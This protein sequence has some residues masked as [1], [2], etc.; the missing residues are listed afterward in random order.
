MTRETRARWRIDRPRND[1]LLRAAAGERTP[2]PPVWLMRQAGRF[3]PQYLALRRECGLELE[4]LFVN[5]ELAAQITLLPMRLGVDAL[6]LF[7][8]ILTPLGP[9]GAPFV[10]RPGPM[11]EKPIRSAADIDRLREYDPAEALACVPDSIQC[12]LDAVDGEIP[13]LG[14]AGSPLT[15]ATF[16]IE[17]GSAAGDVSRTRELM[18]TDP[19][20]VHRLLEK[21]ADMT[22]AYLTMQIEAGVHGVQLF[23][24]MADLFT[25]DEYT[26]F[27]QPYQTRV[28][29]GTPTSAP[30][31][32]FAREFA[33]VE[34]MV[35]TGADVLS[36]GRCVNLPDARARIGDRIALQGNVDNDILLRGTADDVA[37]AT[38]A[39]I[40]AGDR[41]GHIVNLNHGILKDTPFDNVVRLIDTVR[42]SE[43]P[44][45][46]E[47][48]TR[49]DATV[50]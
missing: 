20:A 17:G 25:R 43:I 22:A 16:L 44:A 50:E 42:T 29:S 18:N 27:A 40:E 12:V 8:D 19:G 41:T 45:G 47:Q 13:L 9:M 31:F 15:L 48:G 37:A 38:R 3:D 30:R 36:V 49:R 39:C 33:N 21:L 14:F 5:P 32:L 4:D 35:T 34:A 11:L 1:L 2:R 28:F 46:D 23:E 24:S 6:I 7:Q 26:A 10:F